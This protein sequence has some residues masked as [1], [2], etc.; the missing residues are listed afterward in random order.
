MPDKTTVNV[1]TTYPIFVVFGCVLVLLKLLDVG[2]FTT[3]SWWWVT[4][5]FWA[6]PAI[7]LS[8]VGVLLAAAGIAIWWADR[9]RL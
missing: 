4:A 8:V 6:P 1:T 5:P 2:S 3:L 7:G 9:K